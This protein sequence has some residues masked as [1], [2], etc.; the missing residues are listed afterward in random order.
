MTL[1]LV[2]GKQTY[3]IS[4][5][6]WSEAL[7]ERSPGDTQGSEASCSSEHSAAGDHSPW[8]EEE[9]GRLGAGAIWLRGDTC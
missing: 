5:P 8:E 6:E 2:P 9:E 7:W 4:S 1:L 3:R